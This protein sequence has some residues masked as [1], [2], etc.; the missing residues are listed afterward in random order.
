MKEGDGSNPCA[1][2][3]LPRPSQTPQRPIRLK[4]AYTQ[5]TPPRASSAD[6]P[7]DGWTQSGRVCTSVSTPGD[8]GP[9]TAA[10]R[11]KNPAGAGLLRGV[12]EGTRTPDRLD[13]NHGLDVI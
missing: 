1:L 4:I 6:V 9:A 7:L 5:G 8:L 2:P 3:A 11:H 10:L 13:H 12:S